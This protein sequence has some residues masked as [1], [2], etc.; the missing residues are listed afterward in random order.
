VEAGPRGALGW[1]E[2]GSASLFFWDLAEALP[3]RVFLL[4]TGPEPGRFFCRVAEGE[5]EVG[6]YETPWP[7]HAESTRLEDV[8]GETEPARIAAALGVPPE[9]LHL[10]G[11]PRG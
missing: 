9:L 2:A 5:A 3:G 10:H 7:E 1:S 4:V 8:D 11:T 6:T